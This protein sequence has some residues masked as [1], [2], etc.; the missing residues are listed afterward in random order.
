M[1]INS[2]K[3]ML[4]ILASYTDNKLELIKLEETILKGN[5]FKSGG[6][7]NKSDEVER[8]MNRRLE[9]KDYLL[10]NMK[11]VE[12]IIELLNRK[13]HEDHYRVMYLKFIENMTLEEIAEAMNKSPRSIQRRYEQAKKILFRMIMKKNGV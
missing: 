4:H 10:N 13:Y 9:R 11:V 12:S 2:M 3:D 5:H 8:Q 6:S 7:R 1:V